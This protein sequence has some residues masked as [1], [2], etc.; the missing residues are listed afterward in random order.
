MT[1]LDSDRAGGT[2]TSQPRQALE[3]DGFVACIRLQAIEKTL[4]HLR[5]VWSGRGREETH[6]NYSA[7][8]VLQPASSLFAGI[9]ICRTL[10]RRLESTYRAVHVSDRM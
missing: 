10:S 4:C 6:S 5:L 2:G 7:S 8:H 9:G 3:K 1:L